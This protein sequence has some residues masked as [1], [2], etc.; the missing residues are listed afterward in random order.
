MK[1]RN[2]RTETERGEEMEKRNNTGEGKEGENKMADSKV[3][4]V[5]ALP[6]ARTGRGE[7]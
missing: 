4:P 3:P 5:T 6:V 7:S 1:G 2:G